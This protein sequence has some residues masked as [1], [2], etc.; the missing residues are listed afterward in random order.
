MFDVPSVG[1]VCFAVCVLWT[2]RYCSADFGPLY[3]VKRHA[4]YS[5][6]YVRTLC[7]Y[8]LV[9]LWR[10]RYSVCVLVTR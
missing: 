10:A 9:S 4:R 3:R 8:L 5:G 6:T 1:G 7:K 2:A